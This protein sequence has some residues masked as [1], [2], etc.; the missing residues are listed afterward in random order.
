MPIEI[1]VPSGSS[2]ET[3]HDGCELCA[4]NADVSEQ[5][6]VEMF[7]FLKCPPRRAPGK[8]RCNGFDRRSGAPAQLSVI[9]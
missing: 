5:T 7:E 2:R 4:I 3:A 6:V 1:A 9:G 8:K